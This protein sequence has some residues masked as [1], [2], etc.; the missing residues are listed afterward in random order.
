[1]KR[2]YFLIGVPVIAAAAATFQLASNPAPENAPQSNAQGE[3]IV[4]VQMPPLEGNSL[5]GQ[6]IF[7]R[8]CA[9]C[10]GDNAAGKEGAGPPLIHIIYEPSHHADE[11]FQRAV[12]LGVRSH[13]WS[14]GD[15]PPVDGL[16]R[17][18]VAMVTAYIRDVQRANG[19]Q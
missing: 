3:P 9:E 4:T 7:T 14:F 16:T 5:I 1:M 19:I 11:A 12:A 6:Q 13:H 10:H 2:K 17:G 8:R 18:D 15:M